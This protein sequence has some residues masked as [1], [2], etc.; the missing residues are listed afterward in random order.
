MM[1]GGEVVAVMDSCVGTAASL[2]VL[3]TGREG[4]REKGR[5]EGGSHHHR[6]QQVGGVEEGGEG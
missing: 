4:G 6:E 3:R 1:G 5:G 2:M